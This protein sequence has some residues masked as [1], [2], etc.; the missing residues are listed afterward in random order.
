MCIYKAPVKYFRSTITVFAPRKEG[1]GDFR[2]WNAQLIRYAGYRQPDG[3]IIGDP[4][5]VAF[6]EVDSILKIYAKLYTVQ[7][8][9]ILVTF[10][11][12]MRPYAL[13]V[14]SLFRRNQSTPS[15]N[16]RLNPSLCKEF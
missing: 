9:G 4:A 10:H 16:R 12:F 3:S 11:I 14:L 6:T 8:L 5:N 1:R 15:H 7:F 2:V 13:C